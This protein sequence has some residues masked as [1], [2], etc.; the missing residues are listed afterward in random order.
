MHPTAYPGSYLKILSNV[1][2]YETTYNSFM[3]LAL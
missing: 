2:S 3:P 1:T